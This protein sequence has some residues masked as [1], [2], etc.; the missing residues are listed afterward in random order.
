MP[1]ERHNQ[2]YYAPRQSWRKQATV[3]INGRQMP[4]YM[5]AEIRKEQAQ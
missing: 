1:F 2:R 4:A 5:A 3:T